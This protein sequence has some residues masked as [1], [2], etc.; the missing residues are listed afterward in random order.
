ML[1]PNG[2][3][4]S[5]YG[6]TNISDE[7]VNQSMNKAWVYFLCGKYRCDKDTNMYG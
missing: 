2:R 1:Y 7:L 6:L 4:L 5:A 3:D